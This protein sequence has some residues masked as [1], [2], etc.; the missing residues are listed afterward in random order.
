MNKEVM[1][2]TAQPTDQ[3]A[4][5]SDMKHL[6]LPFEETGSFSKTFLDYINQ[7]NNLKPFYGLFPTL[8]NFKEQITLKQQQFTSAQRVL[9]SERILAQYE[10]VSQKDKSFPESNIKLL[11]EE[12]TFTVTT[13]HQLN[14]FT[15]PLYFIYKIV[16]TIKLAEQLKETY[17]EYNF[18]PVYWMATEDHDFD[19]IS[20]FKAFGK[21][22][23]WEV[24]NPQGAVGRMSPQGLEQ[25]I[26]RIFDMPDFF[27]TAYTE[28]DNLANATRYFV[29]ELFQEYGLVCVDGDDSALKSNFASVIKEDIINGT[30]FQKVSATDKAIEKAGGKTQIY[31]RP[32]NFFYLKDDLRERI[33]RNGDTFQVVNTEISFTRETLEEEINQ[34]PERF[35]PNVVLRPL[36]QETILPNLAYLGGPAEVVYW[37]Q[38][39][40]VFDFFGTTF[41]MLMP[42]NF[43]MIVSDRQAQKLSKLGF[44]INDIFQK[45]LELKKD[46]LKKHS[47]KVYDLDHEISLF[48]ELYQKINTKATGID[49]SLQQH[50]EAEETKTLKRLKHT[51]EK[52]RKAEQRN[53]SD[54]IE[55]LLKIKSELF[56]NQSP[57]ERAENFMNFYLNDRDLINKLHQYL[58][59]LE[60]HF[61]VLITD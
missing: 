26:A 40:G 3:E 57:Q 18:V 23:Q 29:N 52:L 31:A 35:S 54:G 11:Q 4:F 50:V 45:E 8:E 39:K 37:L 46:F 60:Y 51:A 56:P 58:K 47:D 21:K 15:G 42:R 59:P 24:E 13:G 48:K 30:P 27:K 32:V 2:S 14:I 1:T 41:P 25:I 55:Q 19:E 53:L 28:F 17:P 10:S 33:E 7:E 9:L 12:N 61:N 6:T 16:S 44:E 49:A 5:C 22:Y 38:L 36:Y 34:H 43:A 20:Y